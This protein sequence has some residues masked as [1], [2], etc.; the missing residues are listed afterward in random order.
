MGCTGGWCGYYR[1]EIG[2]YFRFAPMTSSSM[3]Y[4]EPRDKEQLLNGK[5]FFG[6]RIASMR[7]F[8]KWPT[9]EPI[10]RKQEYQMGG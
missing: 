3:S 2:K 5:Q 8:P 4:P 1:A 6:F 10:N 7:M 9:A